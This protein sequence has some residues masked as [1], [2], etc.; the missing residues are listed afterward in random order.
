MISCVPIRLVFANFILSGLTRIYQ[1]PFYHLPFLFMLGKV[2]APS[3]GPTLLEKVLTSHVVFPHFELTFL[4]EVPKNHTPGNTWTNSRCYQIEQAVVE[5]APNQ[6]WWELDLSWTSPVPIPNE[7]Y[8]SQYLFRQACVD[9]WLS[10]PILAKCDYHVLNMRHE[11]NSLS[12]TYD[13][14]NRS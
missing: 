6:S 4:L 3:S 14:I 7:S 2:L 11:N 10:H 13:F 1:P 9:K 12:W 8:V 5:C